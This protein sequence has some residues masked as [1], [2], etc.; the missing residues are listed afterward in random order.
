M[1]ACESLRKSPVRRRESKWVMNE[2]LETFFKKFSSE[3]K[4]SK[5]EERGACCDS[6]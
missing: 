4:S 6:S 3:A 5:I 1:K 2:V